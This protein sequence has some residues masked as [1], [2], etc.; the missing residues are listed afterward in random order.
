MGLAYNKLV[1][2]DLTKFPGEIAFTGEFA[3]SWQNPDPTTWIFS[4][5][6]GA[7]FHNIAPVN[8]REV[9]AADVVYSY[10]RQIDERVNAAV[11]QAMDKFE[12]VDDYTLRIT[13]KRPDADFLWSVEDQRSQIIPHESVEV[14]GH[15]E[16]GPIIGSGPWIFEEWAPDQVTKMRRNPEYFMQ[17][18]PYFDAFQRIT[19]PDTQTLQAAFRTGQVLNVPTTNDQINRLLKSGVPDLQERDAKLTGGA[20]GE[21]L[22]YSPI[23]SPTNDVRVRQAL[24]MI[25][26]REALIRDVLFN[27]GWINAGVYVDSE[28]AVLPK[29]DL[30]RYLKYDVQGAK[31]LLQAAGLDPSSWKPTMDGGIPSD[32]NRN[33]V[34]FYVAQLKQVGIDATLH[35]VDKVEITDKIW[36][37][38]TTEFCVCNK[39]TINGT[40]G[41]LYTF[42]HSSGRFAALYK[43]LGDTRLDQ[44]IDQQATT[45]D[46][47]QRKSILHE[48]QRRILETAVV[49][50]IWSG[51]GMTVL[52]G[53]LRDYAND[54]LEGHRFAEA[55]LAG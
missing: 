24:G 44:L 27:N 19:I 14:N 17:G 41:E 6:K 54:S 34:D 7:K 42:Y 15:L 12:A 21:R 35:V 31:Q 33:T 25:I 55:W 46:R 39:P 47:E 36:L 37:Q 51:R 50:P 32:T 53:K 38:G 29:A 52:A 10:Q 43:Q 13:L 2:H 30:D 26:D 48:V 22:W 8:G 49:T 1:R 20:G 18:L 9:K 11:L 16:Q 4:L 45:L 23:K 40:N 3:E 28:D 5:R